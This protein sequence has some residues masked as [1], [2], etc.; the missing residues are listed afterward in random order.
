MG[1]EVLV[2]LR[3]RV[4]EKSAVMQNLTKILLSFWV[5]RALLRTLG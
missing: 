4:T 5:E 2:V 3:V 1:I